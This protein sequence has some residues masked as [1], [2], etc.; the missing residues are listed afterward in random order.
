MKNTL[1]I[2]LLF[3]SLG[4]MAQPKSESI[5]F[6]ILTSKIEQIEPILMAAKN[7]DRDG[8]FQIVI[9][10]SEV[11]QLSSPTM[12]KY[13]KQAEEYNVKLSVCQMSLDRLKIDPDSIPESITPV[14]NAFLYAFQLQKKGYKTLNI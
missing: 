10:G 6:V 14:D 1:S 12:I 11:N 5:D 4:V 7:A 8:D 9:Y 13:L 2:I 3:L